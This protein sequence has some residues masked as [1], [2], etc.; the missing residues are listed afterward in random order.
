VAFTR[1]RACRKNDNARVEQKNRTHVRE[2]IGYGRLEGA[3]VAKA[4]NE[5]YAKEWG[6]FRNFF[7][8]VMKLIRV[9][10]RGSRRRRVYDEPMTPFE[11]LKACEDADPGQI[12]RL[13]KQL[14]KLDPFMLREDIERKLRAIWKLQKA[15]ERQRAA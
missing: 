10:V 5:L 6:W 4:L 3:E 1:S 2:L 7:C 14:A 15:K 11:R 8:P 13:E 9:E 12:A